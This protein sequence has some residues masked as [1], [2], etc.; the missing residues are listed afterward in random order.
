MSVIRGVLDIGGHNKSL[1]GPIPFIGMILRVPDID[2]VIEGMVG[3]VV[4]KT[5]Q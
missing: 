4:N 3:D 5:Q 1:V 2:V